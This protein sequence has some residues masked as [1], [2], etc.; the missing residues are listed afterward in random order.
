MVENEDRLRRFVMRT[1]NPADV[2]M[3]QYCP[4]CAA[5]AAEIERLTQARDTALEALE[6]ER[7]SR[8]GTA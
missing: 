1:Q 4:G 7:C 6:R 5:K 2:Q 3:E 8:R